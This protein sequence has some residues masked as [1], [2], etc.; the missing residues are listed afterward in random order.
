M[1]DS[2]QHKNIAHRFS[3]EPEVKD[4]DKLMGLPIPVNKS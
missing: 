3:N 4:H 2:I 1:E